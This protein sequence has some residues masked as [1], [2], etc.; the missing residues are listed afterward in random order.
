MK[1]KRQKILVSEKH[2]VVQKKIKK[3]LKTS[4]TEGSFASGTYGFGTSYFS[5]YAL[6]LN[7]TSAQIGI[8]N[9]FAGLLPSLVQ[10]K[11]MRLIEKFSR[12]KVAV[13]S[14]LLQ[15]LMFIPI[16]LVGFLFLS[17]FKY[18]VEVLL[19]FLAL[20][21]ALGAASHPAWFSW[22]GSLV[23]EH[24]RGKYFSKRNK[25]TGFFGLIFMIISALA[26]DK[27]KIAGF[28]LLGFGI[29]FSL[30]F[31][32]RL[33]SLYLLNRQYEPKLKIHKRDYFSLFD[34]LKKGRHTPFGK[35]T[36]FSTFFRI[37]TNI[38]G[39]F[40]VVYML[41]DLGLSYTWFMIII[42]AEIIFQLIF[43]PVLGKFSDK[44]GNIKLLKLSIIG[45][46]LTPLLWLISKNPYYLMTIPAFMSGVGWAGFGLATNNYIYDAVSQEKR[47]YGLTYFNLLTGV[48]LFIGAGIGSLIAF[49]GVNF[50][51]TILFIFVVSSIARLG[52]YFVGAKMLKEVRHVPHFS[53]NFIIK[54]F[55][56]AHGISR[57]IHLM[58]HRFS[59][60]EHYI[61]KKTM[62]R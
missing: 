44:F 17:G 12:K 23:P 58:N 27:F 26:L 48:A 53:Y 52:M 16:I 19:V 13:I 11:V 3:S 18:S 46:G 57:E 4:I 29:L 38:A 41:R 60:V 50:M 32:F 2:P 14:A 51:N 39:P 5:P 6:A 10:L 21:F 8:L 54:K 30:A 61:K 55:Q 56:P 43:Y 7:A 35:F 24:E 40:F 20:F 42:V 28:V 22:M 36:I 34:F 25:I 31:L 49:V 9:A 37:A 1:K 47:A 33:I 15:A 59:K 45:A 62:I